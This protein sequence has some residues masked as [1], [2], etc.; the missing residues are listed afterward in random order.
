[1][2]LMCYPLHDRP[3]EIQPGKP[4]RDWMDAFAARHPYRCL[5]LSMAN[6]TGWDVLCP[7]G[8]TATWNGGKQASDLT[9]EPDYPMPGFSDLVRSHFT[10]GVLTLHTGY[11]FKTP[12]G[13]SIWV[14]GPPNHFK[15]GIAPLTGLVETDWLPFPFT[16]NWRFTR[17]CSVRF[18]KNEPFC[19]ITLMQDK[20]LVEFDIVRRALNDDP[21]VRDQYSAWANKRNE[22][23]KRLHLRDPEAIK[24]AWQR[25]YFKGEMPDESG[26]PPQTHVNKRR[27]KPVRQG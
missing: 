12:P 9:I 27:M 11:L 8:F 4:Q 23:N 3:P 26:P 14:M 25:F 5:P 10:E 18:E 7:V 24:Q 17:P 22:F 16:M 20:P 1:M 19:F 21:D 2:K 6:S 15:D 13:W